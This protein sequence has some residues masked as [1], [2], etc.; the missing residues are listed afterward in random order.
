MTILTRKR[1]IA[2]VKVIEE[3]KLDLKRDLS[4]DIPASAFRRYADLEARNAAKI[5]ESK[6]LPPVLGDNHL[7]PLP[8]RNGV[9]KLIRGNGFHKLEEISGSPRRFQ[10]FLKKPPGQG[11]SLFVHYSMNCGLLSDF[12]K[13]MQIN[14]IDEGLRGAKPFEFWVDNVGP[15]YQDGSQ[16]QVDGLFSAGDSVIILEAKARK[17]RDFV[18]R[19]LYYPYRH[20]R[21][22]EPE[23]SIETYLMR[24]DPKTGIY[25][26]WKYAFPQERNYNSI[27]LVEKAAYVVD[28]RPHSG[29]DLQRIRPD[30]SVKYVPQANRV[31]LIERIPFLVAHGIIDSELLSNELGYAERQGNYYSEAA[32]A[33]GLIKREAVRNNRYLFELT[34]LG[35][36]YMEERNDRRN[37]M[38]AKQMMRLPIMKIT[39]DILVSQTFDAIGS[40]CGLSKEDI[41]TIVRENARLTGKT[42]RRRASCIMSWFRWLSKNYGVVTVQSGRLTLMKS[43]L[44][45]A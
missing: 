43:V 45:G 4:N 21:L 29:K 32:E 26:F 20:W 41:T 34:N 24:I 11:E 19:Q 14:K 25:E 36:T 5:D 42:P 17:C 16:I 6:A 44:D 38:L 40:T 1:D 2:W 28:V 9:Y 27:E 3:L 22:E 35:R 39:F 31:S 7:F 12:T 15:I 23:K 30:N 33:L 37:E 8:I 18:I 10:S 13:K